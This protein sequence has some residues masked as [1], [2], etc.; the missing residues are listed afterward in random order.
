MFIEDCEERGLLGLH[1]DNAR[2]GDILE[3]R[4]RQRGKFSSWNDLWL[5]GRDSLPF[6]M[7]R[8]ETWGAE[9]NRDVTEDLPTSQAKERERLRLA[10]RQ[11]FEPR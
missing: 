2:L 11:G 10:G 4:G 6:A 3:T 9:M 8:G 1:A 7:S 5:G